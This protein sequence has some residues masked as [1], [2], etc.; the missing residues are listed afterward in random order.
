MEKKFNLAGLVD[1]INLL[2]KRYWREILLEVLIILGIYATLSYLNVSVVKVIDGSLIVIL[3]ALPVT[4][5]NWISGKR[6]K[7]FS[8]NIELL[9]NINKD[10]CQSDELV[11]L[12][13]TQINYI[14]ENKIKSAEE[15]KLQETII[16]TVSRLVLNGI[17]TVDE[18]TR[19]DV[20]KIYKRLGIK[21]TEIKKEQNNKDQGSKTDNDINYESKFKVVN[22]LF[23]KADNPLMLKSEYTK[24]ALF[25]YL[26][27]ETELSQQKNS[28][29]NVC[30]IANSI[31][32]INDKDF[33]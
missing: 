17:S 8:D 20:D 33:F 30:L 22:E 23:F 12:R 32:N 15:R 2:L 5:Y 27:Y 9:V 4:I 18:M 6:E 25:V 29:K 24:S 13:L 26:N 10:E 11:D 31:L 7:F 28:E 21:K 14:Y 3:L 16:N 1:N 19:E